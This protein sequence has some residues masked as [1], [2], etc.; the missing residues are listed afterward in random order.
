MSFNEGNLHDRVAQLETECSQLRTVAAF[1][2]DRLKSYGVPHLAPASWG[3]IVRELGKAGIYLTEAE[4]I[5]AW[6]TRFNDSE[7]E[8][9]SDN[10]P[11]RTCHADE[12]THRN[13]KYSINRG[14]RER[15][16]EWEYP[17]GVNGWIGYMVCSNCGER[18]DE[19]VTDGANY[20][21]NCGAKVVGE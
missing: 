5:R 9:A 2:A 3:Y 7:N 8:E 21:Q 11:L 6:N 12:V 13:C 16:C 4:A 1:M 20:C 19:T 17:Q 15:T 14:W 10:A 18:Y